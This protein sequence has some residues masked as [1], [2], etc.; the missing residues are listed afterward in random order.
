MYKRILYPDNI[1]GS[2]PERFGL[3]Y[4]TVRFPGKDGAILNGWFIPAANGLSTKEAKGT[5]VHMH[6]NS[7]NISSHWH[8]AGWLPDQGYNVFAFDY[9]GFGKSFGTAEPKGIYESAV[10]ALAYIRTRTD[11]DTNKIFIYGQS[12]GGSVA[13]AAAVAKPEGVRAVVTESAFYSYSSMVDDRRPGEGYGYEQDDIYSGGP[14]VGKL[15]PIPLLILHG[16]YDKIT[17][18]TESERLYAEAKE[19]KRIEIIKYGR[20]MDAMTERYGDHFQK[21][22]TGFFEDAV[23]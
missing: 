20:H 4:E 15:S 5:V 19:P 3:A 23:K 2:T 22:V 21:M 9:T 18:Y 13:I 16:N 1:P 7:G 10:A 8:F 14:V 12:M 17:S 11:I 6:A